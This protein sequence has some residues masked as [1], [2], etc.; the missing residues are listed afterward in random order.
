MGEEVAEAAGGRRGDSSRPRCPHGGIV[1]CPIR[2]PKVTVGGSGVEDL[3]HVI[4]D[5]TTGGRARLSAVVSTLEIWP[6]CKSRPATPAQFPPD[7]EMRNSVGIASPR[8]AGGGF[9]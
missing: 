8:R 2:R 6:Y 9:Q 5:P 1:S 7:A 4:A 3:R